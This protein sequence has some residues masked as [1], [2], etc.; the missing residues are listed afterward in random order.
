M[1]PD[2]YLNMVLNRFQVAINYHE[3][4]KLLDDKCKGETDQRK[5]IANIVVL[6][7][8]KKEFEVQMGLGIKEYEVYKNQSNLIG[9]E[10]E[11]ENRI[12]S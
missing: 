10:V 12:T 8:I 2:Q 3:T 11:D 9:V 1:T 6:E 4:I 5:V 7:E